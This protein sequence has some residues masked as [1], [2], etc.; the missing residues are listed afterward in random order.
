MY[1]SAGELS[2]YEK[3]GD[4]SGHVRGS[5]SSAEP[6]DPGARAIDSRVARQAATSADGSRQERKRGTLAAGRSR[7]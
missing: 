6:L 5:V 2:E 4:D 1:R 3:Y 7:A